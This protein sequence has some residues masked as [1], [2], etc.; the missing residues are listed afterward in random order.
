[1]VNVQRFIIHVFLT[2]LNG[3]KCHKNRV[4]WE[5]FSYLLA[6]LSF[7]LL[8]GHFN[9]SK[10]VKSLFVISPREGNSA[11]GARRVLHYSKLRFRSVFRNPK[12]RLGFA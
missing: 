9:F 7:K 3:L 5:T 1:M 10:K 12:Q 8:E 2:V 6:F 4:S 11:E